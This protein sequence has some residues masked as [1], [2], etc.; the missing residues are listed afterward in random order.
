MRSLVG[1]S[2]VMLSQRAAV[3]SVLGERLVRVLLSGGDMLFSGRWL[4]TV[5][6]TQCHS[7]VLSRHCAVLPRR[8]ELLSC[9]FVRMISSRRSQCTVVSLAVACI[10]Y[11]HTVTVA[12]SG[13]SVH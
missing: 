13:A 9:Q 5:I 6:S 12:C 11:R 2:V 1:K 8:A 4:I 7:A 3:R 10:R